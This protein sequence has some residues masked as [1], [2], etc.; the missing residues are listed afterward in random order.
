MHVVPQPFHATSEVPT[1]PWTCH[2]DLRFMGV[3]E[4]IL[5]HLNVRNARTLCVTAC[6]GALWHVASI[7]RHRLL[8]SGSVCT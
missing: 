7:L 8:C 6:H 4:G 2:A 1:L 3:W 5:S